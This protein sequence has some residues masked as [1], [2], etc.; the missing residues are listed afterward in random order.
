[1]RPPGPASERAGRFDHVPSGEPRLLEGARLFNAGEFFESHE[2]W[3][4]LWHEVVGKE[5]ALLQGLIQL[6]AA[7]HHLARGNA[8]GARYLHGRARARLSPWLPEHAG[9][10]LR[11]L[12]K[13]AAQHFAEPLRPH[14]L[15]PPRIEIRPDKRGF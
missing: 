10:D 8:R 9:V 14:P 6:A 13:Q 5:R 7:Y 3:E 1:M 4:S 11:G 15:A 12:L 2:A